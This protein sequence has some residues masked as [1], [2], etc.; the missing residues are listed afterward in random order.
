MKLEY[1]RQIF[2]KFSNIKF[3][4]NPSSGSQT[5]PCGQTDLTKLLVAFAIFGTNLKINQ[6]TNNNVTCVFS[7]RCLSKPYSHYLYSKLIVLY[8][9][10]RNNVLVVT[11]SYPVPLLWHDI[12]KTIYT[13]QN[14]DIHSACQEI[15]CLLWKPNT[16]YSLHKSWKRMIVFTPKPNFKH[17]QHM[18]SHSL[19]CP[20]G[21]K[22]RDETP[23]QLTG[24]RL[25]PTWKHECTKNVCTSGKKH[26]HK[27]LRLQTKTVWTLNCDP[28]F[29]Q[30]SLLIRQYQMACELTCRWRSKISHTNVCPL[31]C[32]WIRNWFPHPGCLIR[33]AMKV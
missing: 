20:V 11:V 21:S 16:R 18:T 4:E 5:V 14:T 7:P 26:K 2:E 19:C 32:L 29:C 3:H 28:V 33:L 6:H 12:T 1:F 23:A 30:P 10:M 22:C 13:E 17:K 24:Y 25:Q 31:M 15:H 27:K 9:L 8:W